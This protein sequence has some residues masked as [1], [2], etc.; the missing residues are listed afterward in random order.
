MEIYYHVY[1]CYRPPISDINIAERAIKAGFDGIAIGD[2]FH[3][4]LDTWAFM[5]QAY[6][7]LGALAGRNPSVP[8]MTNV[9]CPFG[10]YSPPLLAQLT[11]TLAAMSDAYFDLGVGTGAAVNESPFIEE[12][13]HW[14]K[15]ANLT[16][17]A[18]TVL[19]RLWN[20]GGD[21]VTYRGEHYTY[22]DVTLRTTPPQEIET[23]WAAWGSQSC[24]YAARHADHL[25]TAAQ[26]ETIENDIYPIYLDELRRL[27]EDPAVHRVCSEAIVNVGPPE[28]ILERLRANDEFVPARQKIDDPDP[29]SIQA[30]GRDRLAEVD[31]K[32]L[33]DV[34]T[35]TDD[36]ETV[37]ETIERY[38][39]AG[40]DR[41]AIGPNCSNPTALINLFETH[42]FSS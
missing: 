9:S 27:G 14:E 8:L 13:P 16:A 22:E 18:L 15:R 42:I 21:Y 10:R 31:D 6:V 32:T 23:Y 37:Q 7:W 39:R 25:A 3:P 24:R 12:W 29:R 4:W 30:E 1:P 40:V 5:H 19:D 36:P 34:Y 2:G 41:L 28:E 33:R 38:R 35:I 26:P 11:A 17:E 20:A